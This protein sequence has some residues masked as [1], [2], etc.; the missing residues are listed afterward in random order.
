MC[1]A[2]AHR[3][4]A[5]SRLTVEVQ[6]RIRYGGVPGGP[7]PAAPPFAR[8][9]RRLRLRARLTQEELADRSGL[10]VEAIS[11]LERG[12]RRHPRRATRALLADALGLA[13]P[14]RDALLAQTPLPGR[15]PQLRPASAM[16]EG[17]V[18]L[19]PTRLVGRDAD[20]ERARELV[21]R[22]DVRLVTITGPAGVGKSR[23]ALQVAHE[24]AGEFEEVVLASL[25]ALS[26]PD[27][28]GCAIAVAL[29]VPAGPQ[30]LVD[31]LAARLSS[32][33]LLLV[34][35]D[36]ELLV[37]AASLLAEVLARCTELALLVTSRRPLR[38]RGEHEIALQPLGAAPAATL[39]AERALAAAP[40]LR[41]GDAEAPAIAG[42]CAALDGLPLALE[43]AAPWVRML[44]PEA[45]D[46]QLRER[47]LDL[48]AQGA[49]DLP[50]HQRTMRDTLRRSYELLSE[51]ERALFRRLSVF[52]GS[53]TLSA[54]RAV[55]EAAGPLDGELLQL[56]AGL[57]DVHLVRRD[58][59]SDELRFGMLETT[60]AFGRELLRAAGE[61]EATSRAHERLGDPT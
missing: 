12:F 49:Q 32:R 7:A 8:L 17:E 50:E 4:P 38:I 60:R 24:L 52:D 19:P 45:L 22:A 57:L 33:R 56:A 58:R 21:G 9:L 43:L 42:I 47:R 11:A 5:A 44:S 30:P 40:E 34:V 27:M 46:A 54:V 53:P 2:A 31:R 10:S 26:G 15:G 39:F 59:R 29:G 18:P 37:P 20:L 41:L 16:P 36:F 3:E 14:E 28:A 25:A 61:T 23:L 1:R 13:D 6:E 51:E 55:Y 35:D 48:L